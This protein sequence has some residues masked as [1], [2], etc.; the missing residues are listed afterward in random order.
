LTYDFVQEAEINASHAFL[1]L[2]MNRLRYE[3]KLQLLERVNEDLNTMRLSWEDLISLPATL[4]TELV[5]PSEISPKDFFWKGYRGSIKFR[6]VGNFPFVSKVKNKVFQ[7]EVGNPTFQLQSPIAAD[8]IPMNW[9]DLF[10]APYSSHTGP[11]YVDDETDLTLQ[12]IAR[13][14]W[15]SP[16]QHSL[17][18]DPLTK[19]VNQTLLNHVPLSQ[20]SLR[21]HLHT[22]ENKRVGSYRIWN[23]SQIKTFLNVISLPRRLFHRCIYAFLGTSVA[24]GENQ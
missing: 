22:P 21:M 19:Q 20:L 13:V 10:F 23:S 18:M 4:I 1:S 24:S 12:G 3:M 8:P 16:P 14:R 5:E 7:R 17:L 6:I 15:F 11:I 2:I 9:D